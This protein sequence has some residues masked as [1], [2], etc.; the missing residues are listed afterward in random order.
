MNREVEPG[1]AG[2]DL[3]SKSKRRRKPAQPE[4]GVE[5]I[6]PHWE[7]M[8]SSL[9]EQ[10]DRLRMAA[11]LEELCKAVLESRVEYGTRDGEKPLTET[12]YFKRE[13]LIDK[14]LDR[15][16]KLLT[17]RNNDEEERTAVEE[18]SRREWEV[19]KRMFEDFPEFF[20]IFVE[21]INERRES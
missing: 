8:Q 11:S 19:I 20:Q 16:A 18:E 14:A 4:Y 10:R 5:E 9:R 2:V 12:A 17:S 1:K 6:D 21:R 3:V 15:Y 7:L 13:A